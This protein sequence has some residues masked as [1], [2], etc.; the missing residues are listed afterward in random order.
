M[1]PTPLEQLESIDMLRV[2][3]NGDEIKLVEISE[4]T[5]PVDTIKDLRKVE[6]LMK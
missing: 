2:I 3:E 1:R 4:I 5:Y 6:R